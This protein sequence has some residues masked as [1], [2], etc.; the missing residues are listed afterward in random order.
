M[1]M[2]WLNVAPSPAL[3][4][5]PRDAVSL[6][7]AH[8]AINYWEHYSSK[9]LMGSQRMSVELMMA[10]RADGTWAAKT[11]ARAM[12][13]Q[14]GK[15][16]ELEVVEFYGLTQRGEW[17]VHTAHELATSASAHLRMMGLLD[18]KDFRNRFK[19]RWGNGKERIDSSK[20]SG[21]IIVYRTRTSGGGR[22]LDDISRLV[23]DEAQ[24]AQPEELASST[25][26]VLANP[27]GQFN[28]AGTGAI[29]GK[30]DWWWSMRIRALKGDD[31]DFAFL[32]HSAEQIRLSER[33]KVVSIHPDPEDREAW[34]RANP[35]YG[36]I[37][38]EREMLAEQKILRD[39]FPREQLG[40]WDPY[41]D[42]L[43]GIIP[44][45]DWERAALPHPSPVSEVRY[46]IAVAP[47]QSYAAIGSAGRVHPGGKLY[48]DFVEYD[49]GTDWVVAKAAR[50]WK[51]KRTPILI[52]PAGAEG[53]LIRSLT[54]EGV[55]IE[56]VSPRLYQQ[57]CGR[58][59]AAV[60]NNELRHLDQDE[61]NR[62]VS[63][64]DRHD[65]GREGG[66]VWEHSHVADITPLKAATVALAGVA[67]DYDVLESVV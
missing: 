25:P 31:D 3:I 64:A 1:S 7:E 18:H 26:I 58:V 40:V 33:G 34:R 12:P 44:A 27:N 41:N 24:H 32:E 37:F 6:D 43:D 39:L 67:A 8:E 30:S 56:E 16:E 10:E 5:R 66:W 45:E 22:G 19:A 46:G 54:D 14:N 52:D 61:M 63:V 62:A 11:T 59:L 9:T 4:V 51:A 13:R 65:V 2:K 29:L 53:M 50:Y 57:S 17:I 60:K 35:G 42:G 28:F 47:D 36:T 21:G 23:V 15:G 20:D 55:G 49:R 38:G 48:I